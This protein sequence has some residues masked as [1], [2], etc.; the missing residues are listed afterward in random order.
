M[1]RA[2]DDELDELDVVVT[3]A[4]VARDT[5]L[6]AAEPADIQ[7][8]IG[9]NLAGTIHV[10]REAARRMISRRRGAIVSISSVA[11]QR[12]GRGQPPGAVA[13]RGS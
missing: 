9:V 1:T 4:G 5:L 11:A 12:P 7:V 2:V 3:C 10:C 13:T 6:G 8:V